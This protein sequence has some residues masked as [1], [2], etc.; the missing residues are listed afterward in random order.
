MTDI[1]K[2][3]YNRLRVPQ[4]KDAALASSHPDVDLLTAFME[5]AVTPPGRESVLGH[6]AVCEECREIVALA[7]PAAE[8]AEIFDG[9]LPVQEMPGQA[10]VREPVR[11]EDDQQVSIPIATK[12]NRWFGFARLNLGWA[13]L[14]AGVAVVASMLVLHPLQQKQATLPASNQTVAEN[15]PLAADSRAVA[16]SQPSAEVSK[17][18]ASPPIGS[19]N[20]RSN[21]G[22]AAL[23]ADNRYPREEALIARKPASP[24]EKAKPAL[25]N[26]ETQATSA[27]TARAFKWKISA[28]V[29]ERS[30]DSGRS[31]Q[32]GLRAD[33]PLLC[34]ASRG[35]DIWVG[36]QAGTL[37]HSNDDGLTWAQVRASGDESLS[38]DVTGIDLRNTDVA[39][40]SDVV[41]EI[42]VST[43]TGEVWN[44]I[45]GGNTWNRQ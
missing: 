23:V 9:R 24:I 43:G 44:S 35:Q 26:G 14:A 22:A 45:D 39:N 16:Q 41:T 10:P 30:F 34:Y 18:K 13:A 11:E 3:V 20:E 27:S 37:L 15:L 2:I 31:W 42:V 17:R 1:P 25:Q 5:Q 40:G 6:L 32:I 4:L 33:H 28:G 19:K 36:G 38:A 29:L 8:I 12:R 7:M 21:P